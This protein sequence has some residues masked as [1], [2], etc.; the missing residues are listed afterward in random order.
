MPTETPIEMFE[1][2]IITDKS[3]KEIKE[4]TALASYLESMG[5]VDEKYAGTLERKNENDA[6]DIISLLEKPNNVGLI[7]YA[8]AL[9]LIALIVFIFV[10]IIT[11][12]KRKAKKAARKAAKQKLKEE[13]R[14]MKEAK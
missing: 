8:V 12:K 10:R 13:K 4:W 11:R 3:G 9:A 14:K 5:E 7:V 1:N 6:K 2:N